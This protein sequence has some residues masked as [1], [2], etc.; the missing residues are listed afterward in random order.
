MVG[1][2]VERLLVQNPDVLKVDQRARGL[3]SLSSS[4]I[5]KL[6]FADTLHVLDPLAQCS[7]YF[8]SIF[9]HVDRSSLKLGGKKI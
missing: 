4:G 3:S 2:K 8:L 5:A 6:F 7:V 1:Q 9:Y